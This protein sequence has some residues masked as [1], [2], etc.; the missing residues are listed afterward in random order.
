MTDLL[1]GKVDNYN[2][3]VEL[4][5][6]TGS[7]TPVEIWEQKDELYQFAATSK[8]IWDNMT[9]EQRDA[10]LRLVK[11]GIERIY[12]RVE[13]WVPESLQVDGGEYL[14][15]HFR[16]IFTNIDEEIERHEEVTSFQIKNAQQGVLDKL[17]ATT[18]DDDGE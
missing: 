5:I 8:E 15:V 13:E 2:I 18:P 16:L 1:F 7:I 4:K 11:T 10:T 3:G 9:T 17:G 14:D 6:V 12:D